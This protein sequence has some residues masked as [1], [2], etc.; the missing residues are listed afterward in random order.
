MNWWIFKYIFPLCVCLL[1]S[2]AASQAAMSKHEERVIRYKDGWDHL[3]PQYVKMQYAGSMG[4]MSFG[5]GWA[6]G[7]KKQ[8]ETDIFL[9][10]LPKFDGNN[11]HATITLKENYIP[12]RVPLKDSRWMLEPFTVSLYLNK[13]FGDEF[14]DKDPDRYPRQYYNIATNL[15][16]NIA[17][18]QRINLKLKPI[19][20]SQNFSF[21][22]E[23]GTNDLYVISYVSNKYLKLA[24][25]FSL[26]LGVKFSFL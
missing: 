13:I 20:L 2:P 14:W 19:G 5:T 18:G 26:S 6:Y 16:F 22:Y 8:W 24:D 12:W 10:Y 3:I 4:L 17:F 25:V 11:G 7:K 23:I 21:F 15:R 1:L 9:G